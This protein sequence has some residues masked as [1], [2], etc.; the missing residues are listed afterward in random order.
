MTVC[1]LDKPPLIFVETLAL[2]SI[3]EIQ[4]WEISSPRLSC[5]GVESAFENRHRFSD[6]ITENEWFLDFFHKSLQETQS[7]LSKDSTV[8]LYT[9]NRLVVAEQYLATKNWSICVH[10]DC[11]TCIWYKGTH[12][13]TPVMSY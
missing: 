9:E 13:I 12:I 10:E 3:I 6:R 5:S 4:V 1:V 11:Q 2:V 7:P 8:I